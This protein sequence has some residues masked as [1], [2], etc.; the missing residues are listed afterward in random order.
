MLEE[1]APQLVGNRCHRRDSLTE[2]LFEGDL[3]HLIDSVLNISQHKTTTEWWLDIPGR[4]NCGATSSNPS[5]GERCIQVR[6]DVPGPMRRGSVLLEFLTIW[7]S[8]L[9]DS[10]CY[11]SLNQYYCFQI[12][13]I[14]TIV[15]VVYDPF[16]VPT[17]CNHFEP[18]I[19]NATCIKSRRLW[20]PL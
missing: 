10:E 17:I 14:S 11:D 6:S 1:V 9:Q 8:Y 5:I 3:C 13:R 19:T 4:H 20:N 16:S 18:C 7:N 15:K 12:A 2:L